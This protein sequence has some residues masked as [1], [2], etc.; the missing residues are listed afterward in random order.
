MPKQR[1][2]GLLGRDRWSR[3]LRPIRVESLSK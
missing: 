2:R 1:N 3:S